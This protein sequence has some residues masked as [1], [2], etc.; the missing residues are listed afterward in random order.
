MFDGTDMV[1][2]SA[3]FVKL[4]VAM[5]NEEGGLTEED[6]KQVQLWFEKQTEGKLSACPMCKA[7]EWS[8]VDV[9]G[10]LRVSSKNFHIGPGG[11]ALPLISMM[12][13]RCGH[14]SFFNAAYMGIVGPPPAHRRK[15]ASND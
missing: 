8:L 15:E 6:Q 7:M 11:R 14:M 9:L 3:C 1:R 13:Q 5:P 4:G 10:E 12:C 2:L